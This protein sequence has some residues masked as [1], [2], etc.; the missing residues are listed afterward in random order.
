MPLHC[1]CS[2]RSSSWLWGVRWVGWRTPWLAPLP[3][4][5]CHGFCEVGI[6]GN[7]CLQ[8]PGRLSCL[9]VVPQQLSFAGLWVAY[10][11][12]QVRQSAWILH[13]VWRYRANQD[14]RVFLKKMFYYRRI[15]STER[16]CKLEGLTAP[17]LRSPG[18]LQE[19]K[20]VFTCSWIIRCT[21]S[22]SL[23]LF[24]HSVDSKKPFWKNLKISIPPK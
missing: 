24:K 2:P 12:I 21:S 7:H 6:Y 23:F 20:V 10:L 5:L 8:L 17:F 11:R 3:P 4:I 22:Q 18:C 16:A 19:E 1:F 13:H 14:G 15:Q 9:L